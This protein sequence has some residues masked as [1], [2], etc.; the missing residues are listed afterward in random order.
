V[1]ERFPI[2]TR[3]TLFVNSVISMFSKRFASLLA[4]APAVLAAH[5]VTGSNL[6]YAAGLSATDQDTLFKGMQ[7]GKYTF[8][9]GDIVLISLVWQLE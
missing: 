9:R 6:Y 5:V 8:R 7:S 4:L 3:L 2:P 1:D